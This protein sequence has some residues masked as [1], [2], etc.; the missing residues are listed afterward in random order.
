M[1]HIQVKD[2]SEHEK[3][4]FNIILLYTVSILINAPG[5]TAIHK[6]LK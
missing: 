2:I 1:S 3:C 6:Y 5:G 4:W